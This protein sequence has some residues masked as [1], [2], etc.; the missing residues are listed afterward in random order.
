MAA[1]GHAS[2]RVD[3]AWTA[4]SECPRSEELSQRTELRVPKDASVRARGTVLRA[5]GRYRA[6]ID[7]EA[8]SS[9]GERV[10]ED[11]SCDALA[12]AAAV[13][14]GM[15]VSLAASPAEPDAP[16]EEE[17]APAAPE[18]AFAP[19][20]A[21]ETSERARPTHDENVYVTVR[22]EVVA[23]SGALPSLSPGGGGAVGLAAS[24]W[25]RGEIH[26]AIFSEQDAHGD[27]GRGA[28]IGLLEAGARGCVSLT[29]TF[30]VLPC[31]GFDV[32]HLSARGFGAQQVA[33]GSATVPALEA[34]LFA[35]APLAGPFGLVAGAGLVVPLTRESFVITSRGSVHEVGAVA[36]R[37]WFGPEVRF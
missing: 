22:L 32:M 34:A 33:H 28:S 16:I 36:F 10:L 3:V 6:T 7:I 12:S 21:K 35:R 25:F 18:P 19:P 8:G 15:S 5:G 9:H 29:K 37:G 26:G 20:P 4:P 31:V 2:D 23:D 11:R 17:K 27:A 13:V 24:R 14:I 30:E 1:P